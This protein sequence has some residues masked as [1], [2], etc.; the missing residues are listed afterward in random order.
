VPPSKMTTWPGRIMEAPAR[1]K[2]LLSL[3]ETCSRTLSS[4][5]AAQD[6]GGLHE[7]GVGDGKTIMLLQY[8]ALVGL[9]RLRDG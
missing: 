7:P 5:T 3:G 6:P 1:P 9:D 8:A 4:P 2:S